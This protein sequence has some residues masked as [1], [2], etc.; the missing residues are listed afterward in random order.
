[1]RPIVNGIKKEYKSC[2]K[3][4]ERVNFHD[5]TSWHELIIPVGPPEFALLDENNIILYRWV[6]YTEK[7]E[8]AAVLDP[9]CK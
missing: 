3:Q 9:L 1:M 4:V 6:G 5:K 8:F 7:Q 2:I